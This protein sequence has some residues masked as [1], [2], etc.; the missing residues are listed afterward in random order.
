M[1]RQGLNKES[2]TWYSRDTILTRTGYDA[3]SI[4]LDES[5]FTDN[6]CKAGTPLDKDGKIANDSNV[7]GILFHDVRL[8]G[9]LRN[10]TGSVLTRAYVSLSRV[11]SS[12]GMTISDDVKNKLPMIRFE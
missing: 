9:N 2:G 5:A 12:S 10:A 8:T 4:T 1:A 6:V 3:L 7:Y 11:E